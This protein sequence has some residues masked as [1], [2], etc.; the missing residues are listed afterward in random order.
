MPRSVLAVIL[1][2]ATTCAAQS[3]C[4]ETL[5]QALV[6]YGCID[7][8]KTFPTQMRAQAE[9][10]MSQ[11]SSLNDQDRL[12][13][14]DAMVNSVNVDRLIKSVEAD[15]APSCDSAQTKTLLVQI[16]TP[17]VQKMRAMEAFTN[18]PGAAQR[19]QET[20]KLPDVQSPSEKRS[21]LIREL[22]TVTGAADIAVDAA[23]Q[24]S[25][26]MLKGMGAPAGDA[27]HVASL[28]SQ[29]QRSA[30]QQ[31]TQMML[32]VYHDATDEELQ[33]YVAILGTKAFRDFNQSFARAMVK[34]FAEES[35]QAGMALR[36]VFEEKQLQRD[37]AKT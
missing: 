2:A 3:S 16:N 12:T 35:R 7:S 33:K 31:I 11:D 26:A 25:Q 19:V 28:S 20:L 32:V 34:S 24:T 36:K 30:Q 17:L 18:S 4:S 14:V 21:A 27:D 37:K 23:V 9:S 10:Q 15:M 6:A 13:I 5:H 8:L 1:L 22:I 29:I